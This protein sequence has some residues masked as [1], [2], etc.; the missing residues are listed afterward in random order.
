MTMRITDITE[1]SVPL[2]GDV[3]NAVVDFSKHTVSLV[4]VGAVDDRGRRHVGVGFNSIGRFA[5]GGL[6]RDRMIPRLLAAAPAALLGPSGEL[7]PLAT[8]AVMMT[9]EKPG[10]HGDRAGAVAAIEL[11]CWDLLAKHH[12]EPAHRTIARSCDTAAPPA[13]IHV[14]A[15]GGYYYG[16]GSTEGLRRELDGYLATGFTDVKIKIGGLPLV[17]DLARVEAAIELLGDPG[18]V[19]VDANGRFAPPQA[20]AYAEALSGYGLRWLEEPCDPADFATLAS[21]TEAFGGPV[22]TGEN[23]FSARDVANLLAYGGLRPGKDVLQM[24][25][26]LSYGIG[27]YVTMLDLMAAAGFGRAHAMPHGGHLVNL[28]IGLGLDLGGCEVYPG[29]FQPFGGYGSAVKVVGGRA[30]ASDAPGFG[31]EQM[32][33]LAPLV[34]ELR[35]A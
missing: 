4:A 21:A 26:G 24:D 31:L 13:D 17:E 14:Y 34:R 16:D 18:R 9:D 5:Q 27:E 7:D 1:R 32:P 23:L 29:V 8:R 20:L 28:H 6:M 33:G 19:A 2:E 12:D 15:A 25:A 22:A 11:A 10:G 30:T 3:R 35:R